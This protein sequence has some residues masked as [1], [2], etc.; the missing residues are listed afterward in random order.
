MSQISITINER[1]YEIA[2]DEGQEEHIT[3]LA[4]YIDKRVSELIAAVGQVGDA[5]LLVM[6]SLLISDE[7]SEVY[8]E[9]DELRG[10]R[11]TSSSVDSSSSITSNDLERIASR[12][13]KIADNL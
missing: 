9:L 3:R 5:R 7:L 13:E 8:G 1:K 6:A 4:E 12:I 10:E 11:G 2:C